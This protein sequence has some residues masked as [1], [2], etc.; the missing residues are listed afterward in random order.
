MRKDG[1]RFPAH[2]VVTRRD[3][4]SGNPIGYLIISIDIS[5]KR[6]AE[7]ALQDSTDGCST[8][9]TEGPLEECVDTAESGGVA[10]LIE[11]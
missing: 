9:S 8:L 6:Q 1:T 7:V 10:I 2:I 3:D 5:D 11:R 4:A